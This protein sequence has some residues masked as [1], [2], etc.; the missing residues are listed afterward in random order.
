M[1]ERTHLEYWD[2]N[3]RK[4]KSLLIQRCNSSKDSAGENELAIFVV[5]RILLCHSLNAGKPELNNLNLLFILPRFYDLSW[6]SLCKKGR[7]PKQIRRQPVS[8]AWLM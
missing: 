7:I 4:R 6:L 1:R 3:D 8:V 5:H 2:N